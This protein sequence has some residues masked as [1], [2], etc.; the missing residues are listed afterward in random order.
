[1]G[2]V[3]VRSFMTENTVLLMSNVTVYYALSNTISFF[4]L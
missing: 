3:Q 2:F 4:V 1:M